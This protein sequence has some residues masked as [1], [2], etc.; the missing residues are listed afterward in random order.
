[1]NGGLSERVAVHMLISALVWILVVETLALFISEQTRLAKAL[2]QA[3]MSD[4]VTGVP[5]R[6][7]LEA[8]LTEVQ[9]GD[10]L[11]V[12][13]LDHFK[14]LNDVRGHHAGDTV[15]ADFGAMLRQELRD[16]DY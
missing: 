13:D 9:D 14:R 8:R 4:V 11:V 15:L 5:N 12:C 10:A 2:M 7:A 6:R 3:A 1:M 16:T